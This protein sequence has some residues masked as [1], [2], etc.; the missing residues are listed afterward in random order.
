MAQRNME[1]LT[2]RAPDRSTC[3]IQVVFDDE[4]DAPVG[5]VATNATP[6]DAFLELRNE[7][8][9]FGVRYRVPAGHRGVFEID[10]RFKRS[11]TRDETTAERVF[12]WPW[13]SRF[14]FEQVRERA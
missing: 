11:V 4:L 9:G 13:S 6:L 1:F 5:I 7:D 8:T 2:A 14:R 10:G 3:V 12:P